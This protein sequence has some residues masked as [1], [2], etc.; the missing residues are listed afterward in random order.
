MQ[1]CDSRIIFLGPLEFA[2]PIFDYSVMISPDHAFRGRYIPPWLSSIIKLFKVLEDE[3]IIF[4]N[5]ECTALQVS[6][7][8]NDHYG[9]DS[10]DQVKSLSKSILYFESAIH[11]LLPQPRRD[12]EYAKWNG[13]P[14]QTTSTT[15]H[16]NPRFQGT[17]G[18]VGSRIALVDACATVEELV[19]LMNNGSKRWSWNFMDLKADENSNMINGRVE[20]RSPPGVNNWRECSAWIHF[21]IEFVH[22]AIST[23]ATIQRL[24]Q[25]EIDWQGLM[26]FLDSVFPLMSRDLKLT[27][28]RQLRLPVY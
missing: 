13:S 16:T 5:D 24:V 15:T 17:F 25:F 8:A 6:V 11:A 28:R 20:F 7:S 22:A 14:T 26:K 1:F 27:Y 9:W 18:G 23:S 10:L 4:V 2:S 21:T 19:E 12:N 3:T